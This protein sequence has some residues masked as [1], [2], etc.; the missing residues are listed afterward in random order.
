MADYLSYMDQLNEAERIRAPDTPESL[1]GRLAALPAAWDMLD[2]YGLDVYSKQIVGRVATTAEVRDRRGRPMV[3]GVNFG[4]QDYLSLASHPAVMKAATDAIE[5][6]GVHVGGSA[7]LMGN[8]APSWQLE[9]QLCDWLQ[10]SDCSLFPTGWGAGYGA[11]RA[12]VRPRDH[13][14]IDRLSHASLHEGARAATRHVHVFNHLSLESLERQLKLVRERSANVGILV[15]T[16][17]LFSMDSDVP[18]LRAHQELARRYGATLMVDM[19]HDLGS[20]GANGLGALEQQDMLG[21]VDVVMGSFSKTFTSNGGFVACNSPGLK[22]AIRFGCGPHTFS[23][24]MSPAQASVVLKNLEIVRSSEGAHRRALLQRNSVAL[25]KVV[26]DAGTPAMGI[27]SAVVPVPM[28]STGRCRMVSRFISEGGA[29]CNAVE[30]PAVPREGAR[31]RLQVMADHAL[32]DI[33]LFRGIYTRAL[34]QA[35]AALAAFGCSE[36]LGEDAGEPYD[37]A[38]APLSTIDP[39]LQAEI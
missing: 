13:I 2:D 4:S 16:E 10:L 29:V 20:M 26:A 28:G 14:V 31:L 33:E 35:D 23:N 30:Y 38:L 12:L 34:A 25:R 19:A 32:E 1:I 27:P 8:C 9:Q 22:L 5:R 37:S 21:K 3:T 39:V 36:A 17:S 18:D 15:V 6:Y 11:I 24:A 7:A